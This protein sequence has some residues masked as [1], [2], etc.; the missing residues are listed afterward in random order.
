M[1]DCRPSTVPVECWQPQG[2]ACWIRSTDGLPYLGDVLFDTADLAH[3]ELHDALYGT[4]AH[5]FAHVLGFGLLWGDLL[6]EPSL[7][8]SGNRIAGRDTHFAGRAA[9]AKFND[10]GGD[11][12]AGAKVPVENDTAEY[13]SGALDAHWRESVFGAEMI[14]SLADMGYE[15]DYSQAQSYLLPTVS[16]SRKAGP[17][18]IWLIQLRDDIRRKP[19]R[20]GNPPELPIPVVVR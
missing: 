14:A 9:V 13:G 15:V 3:L 4:V 12:C 5:E 17:G 10:A 7:G 18:A 1:S 2:P 6:K 16:S 20:V 11:T 19:I 8:R